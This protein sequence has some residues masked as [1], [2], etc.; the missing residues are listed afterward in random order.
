[1]EDVGIGTGTGIT[2]AEEVVASEVVAVVVL[3]CAVVPGADE[4][5]STVT[6]VVTVS[7]RAGVSKFRRGMT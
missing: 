7:V 5:T 1:M 4:Q 6:V 3:V 2:G